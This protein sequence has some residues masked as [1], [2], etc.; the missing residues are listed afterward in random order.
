M[1][2]STFPSTH[3]SPRRTRVDLRLLLA[4]LAAGPFAWI[5]QLVIGY[6]VA[7]YACDPR[8]TPALVSPPPGWAGEGAWLVALNLA[9]LI[10]AGAGA[11]LS[12]RN[13][14]R[15]RR[16]RGA[17]VESRVSIGEGRTAFIAACG[18]LAGLGY[19]LA[20]AFDTVEPVF[21]AACWTIAP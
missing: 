14:R 17:D 5:V 20:I 11:A 7:S 9:C 13:W 16:S 2:V 12:W 15:A 3:P 18:A 8:G 21:L 1:T 6:G 4:G 10:L 19:C